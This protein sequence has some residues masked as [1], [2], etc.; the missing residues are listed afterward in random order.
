MHQAPPTELETLLRR[1]LPKDTDSDITDRVVDQWKTSLA[2]AS[3]VIVAR[4]DNYG[5]KLQASWLDPEGRVVASIARPFASESA[6]RKF[7]REWERYMRKRGA[8][9]SVTWDDA[10]GPESN[11]A[12]IG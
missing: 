4:V 6:V 9:P 2:T 7:V 11:G 3:R 5:P 1:H 8:K 12:T 10:A